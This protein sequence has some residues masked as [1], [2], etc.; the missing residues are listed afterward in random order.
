MASFF[1]IFNQSF[2]K[3][4]KP[5]IL[6]YL[7]KGVQVHANNAREPTKLSIQSKS[8]FHLRPILEY[9]HNHSSDNRLCKENLI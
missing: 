4:K 8:L 2:N 7:Q 9:P 3:S 1:L 6:F 5:S